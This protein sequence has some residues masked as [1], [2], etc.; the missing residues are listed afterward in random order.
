M[1]EMEPL[2]MNEL[3]NFAR[4]QLGRP[5]GEE[6]ESL[7]MSSPGDRLKAPDWSDQWR[8]LAGLTHGLTAEDPRLNPILDALAD[9]DR[10]YKAGDL[11][12][13]TD[14]SE[15]VKRL[16]CFAPGAK[17]RWQGSETYRLCILGPATVAQV[18]CSEGRLWAWVF[19]QGIG[20]WVSES[21]IT[22][23]EGPKL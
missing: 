22:K 10:H 16:M 1:T 21:I 20:R 5:I 23:I 11:A 4:Q 9:C 15:R 7:A 19:W 17:V 18:I 8:Q 12:A 13:F 2:I 3:V 6:K 14:T